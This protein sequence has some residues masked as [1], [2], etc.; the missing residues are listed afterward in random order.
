[1]A[2]AAIRALLGDDIE[3]GAARQKPVQVPAPNPLV[4]T[5]AEAIY[6]H[7]GG[8]DDVQHA[9]IW[10]RPREE[11]KTPE[12]EEAWRESWRNGYRMMAKAAIRAVLG[13]DQPEGDRNMH[14]E[15]QVRIYCLEKQK[16]V[17]NLVPSVTYTN[18]VKDA[19]QLPRAYAESVM[20]RIGPGHRLDAVDAPT[21]SA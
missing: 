16:W 13:T 6:R 19:K 15:P 5:V 4:E 1:M 2:A 9:R 21:T 18:D 7:S 17:R 12:P 10:H 3:P 14:D 8:I 11:W 20:H